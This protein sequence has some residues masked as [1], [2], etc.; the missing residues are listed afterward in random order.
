MNNLNGTG[1]K[2]AIVTSRFNQNITDALLE[3]ALETLKQQGVSEDDISQFQVPGA[4]EIPQLAQ[5]LAMSQQYHGV[6]C[7][8]AVIRGETPHFDYVCRE[9]ARGIQFAAMSTGI[10][11]S[12]GILTTDTVK[13][14]L[15]RAGGKH[16]NKGEDAALTIIEMVHVLTQATPVPKNVEN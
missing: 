1:M 14:A 8:G 11:V 15:A 5:R 4:F 16:G 9:A 6:V 12:F 7:L 10:P 2:I 13:Q 3:S